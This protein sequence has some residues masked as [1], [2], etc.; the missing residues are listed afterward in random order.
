MKRRAFLKNSVL[1]AAVS[2]I[3]GKASGIISNVASAAVVWIAPGKLGYKEVS[4]QAANKK[5]CSTC[6]HYQADAAVAGGGK[7][8]LPAMLTAMKAKEVYA[9]EGAYCNMWAKKA[10]A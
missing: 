3:L 10:G 7:C 8:V 4:P 6:K 9:K 2:T 5:L 1:F